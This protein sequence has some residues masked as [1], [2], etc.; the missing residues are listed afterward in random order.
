MHEIKLVKFLN[1]LVSKIYIIHSWF[2]GIYFGKKNVGF[3]RRISLATHAM[4]TLELNVF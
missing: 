3:V 2:V 4:V 1:V